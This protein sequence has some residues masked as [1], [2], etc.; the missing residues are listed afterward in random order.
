MEHNYIFEEEYNFEKMYFGIEKKIKLS[1]IYA[2]IKNL[3]N[4]YDD[5]IDIKWLNEYNLSIKLKRDE[6]DCFDLDIIDKDANKITSRQLLIY[7]S[8]L[9][10]NLDYNQQIELDI[11]S[12]EQFENIPKFLGINDDMHELLLYCTKESKIEY[13]LF[14]NYVKHLKCGCKIIIYLTNS[15]LITLQEEEFNQIFKKIFPSNLKFKAPN[16]F[17]KNYSY[18]FKFY[19]INEQRINDEYNYYPLINRSLFNKNLRSINFIRNKL[20]FLFGKTGIGKSITIIKALKYDYDH[21]KIG[22]IYINCKSMYKN[23]IQNFDLLKQI[24]KDEIPFL[25]ENEYKIYQECIDIINKYQ[26]NNMNTFWDLI[27][28]IIEL[29]KNKDKCYI[30]AFDQYKDEFDQ[31]G[32]LFKL[33]DKLKN[34]NKYGILVCC[35][36]NNKDIREYKIAKLFNEANLKYYPDNMRIEEVELELNNKNFTIDEGGEFDQAFIYVGKT[37]KNYNELL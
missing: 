12:L 30:F 17:D 22:T 31:N 23:Y 3:N 6:E 13:N 37:I 16:E 27:S 29:C 18:Y 19:K 36:M 14:G 7:P 25:F 8:K 21:K 24:L 32:Q 1:D 28:H 10:Y 33:N 9:Y 34:K 26:K 15:N 2:K 35:S 4:N 20:Y 5:K 11:V